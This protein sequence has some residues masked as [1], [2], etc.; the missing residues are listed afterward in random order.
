M[1]CGNKVRS[2]WN[3]S[4]SKPMQEEEK[5]QPREAFVV[6][7][8]GF[9][10]QAMGWVEKRSGL[11]LLYYHR[12][13]AQSELY[14]RPPSVLMRCNKQRVRRVGEVDGREN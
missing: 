6:L 2:R 9:V 4:G 14:V 3:V 12:C 8:T 7:L 10:S 5:K 11:L 1:I 13:L